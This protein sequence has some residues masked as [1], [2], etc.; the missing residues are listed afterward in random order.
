M[1]SLL[2]LY[3]IF[4]L[5]NIINGFLPIILIR[6]YRLSSIRSIRMLDNGQWASMKS[7]WY[8]NYDTISSYRQLNIDRHR[9]RVKMSM[10]KD[11]KE[12]NGGDN[13]EEDALIAAM[14]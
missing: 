12:G 1:L 13:K 5:L 6:S 7:R 8:Y 10:S 14:R 11:D 2:T 4:L 9:H 3:V